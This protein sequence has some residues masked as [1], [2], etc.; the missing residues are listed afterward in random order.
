MKIVLEF[1]DNSW[2]LS[3]QRGGGGDNYTNTVFRTGAYPSITTGT[4]PFTGTYLPET[5]LP[6]FIDNFNPNGKWT[7]HV[8]DLSGLDVGTINSWSITF[9]APTCATIGFSGLPA[10]M[11]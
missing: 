2:I 1:F 10:T 7:L 11:N 6:K 3:N 9:K 5:P 8:F 4:A